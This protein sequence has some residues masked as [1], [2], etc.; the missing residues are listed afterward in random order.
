MRSLLSKPRQ[1]SDKVEEKSEFAFSRPAFFE[2]MS[3]AA[4]AT[5]TLFV[6]LLSSYIANLADD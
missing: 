4:I 6:T 3:N 5:P 1:T 2:E